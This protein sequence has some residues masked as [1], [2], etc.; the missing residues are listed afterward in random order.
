MNKETVCFRDSIRKTFI[1]YSIV[2]VVVTALVLLAITGFAWSHSVTYRNEKEN[3]ETSDEISRVM[4]VWY[5]MTEDMADTFVENDCIVSRDR[6]FEI[7]YERCGEFG[8]TGNLVILS[9]D[10]EVLFTSKGTVPYYLTEPAYSDWGILYTAG[11]AEGRT[12]TGLSEGDICIGKSIYENGGLKGVIVYIVPEAV[13]SRITATGERYLAVTDENGWIWSGNNKMLSDAYGKIANNF[14][15][16]TGY[17]KNDGKLYYLCRTAT[18]CG[19]TVYTAD[20]MSSNIRVFALL[21]AVVVMVFVGIV[22]ITYRSTDASSEKYTADIRK[23][24]A[25]FEA[26]SNGDLDVRLLTDSSREFNTIGNDFNEMLRSLREQIAENRELMTDVAFAQ[27]K[28]LESQLNPHFLFNTLD[29]IRFMAKIDADAADRMIISLSGILRYTIRDTREEV[30]L[31]EDL[32]NLQYYLNILQIRF[33][34]RFKYSIDISEDLMDCLIPKL[35]LQ[36][37]LENAIKHGFGT[38]EKLSVVIRGYKITD[39]LVFVCEDD[40]AGIPSPRLKEIR[41]TLENDTNDT[42]H[43]GLYNIHRRIRLMYKSDYGIDI[44][45]RE[46]EGTLVRILL[47][48]RVKK[49]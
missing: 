9:P 12:V 26:V 8:E 32:N 36:P 2:P 22:F 3:R 7:L 40:G 45:S 38:K 14:D 44:D 28:Q 35:L 5:L 20:D 13:I 23:I 10:R 42:A 39:K 30:T 47:P 11:R 49:G 21:I 18:K 16:E 29:N 37:L 33:N 24:E 31:R 41:E 34:K 1:G 48:C 15:R 4:D 25:A 46:G 17:L 6:I 19:L 43:Y 27:L